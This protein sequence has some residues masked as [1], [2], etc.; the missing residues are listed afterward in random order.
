VGVGSWRHAAAAFSQAWPGTNCIGGWLG[1]RVGLET[2]AENLAST[3]IQSPDRQPVASH[4]TV[5]AITV[6]NINKLLKRDN[7]WY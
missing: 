6:Y 3:G 7:K 1:L 2:G 5:Y 4:Y